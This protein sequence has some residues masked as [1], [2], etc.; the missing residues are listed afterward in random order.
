MSEKSTQKI[1]RIDLGINNRKTGML[2]RIDP[3]ATADQTPRVSSERISSDKRQTLEMPAVEAPSTWS[4]WYTSRKQ[5]LKDGWKSLFG[6]KEGPKQLEQKAAQEIGMINNLA[7]QTT[8]DEQA[9]SNAAI[10]KIEHIAAAEK[11]P[12]NT[13]KVEQ[14]GQR[15]IDRVTTLKTNLFGKERQ[16]AS[17][18]RQVVIEE[19]KSDEESVEELKAFIPQIENFITMQ[20]TVIDR[21]QQIMRAQAEN[22]ERQ[23]GQKAIDESVKN[24]RDKLNQ[25]EEDTTL[26]REEKLDKKADLSSQLS[27]VL[28]QAHNFRTTENE[29]IV[30]AILLTEVKDALEKLKSGDPNPLRKIR[31]DRNKEFK[32][33]APK[34]SQEATQPANQQITQPGNIDPAVGIPKD[35][36][37]QTTGEAFPQV[38]DTDVHST[39]IPD[40]VTDAQID[41]FLS[42]EPLVASDYTT[43]TPAQIAA[44][45]P[46]KRREIAQTIEQRITDQV[47]DPGANADRAKLQALARTLEQIRTADMPKNDSGDRTDTQQAT[48]FQELYNASEAAPAADLSEAVQAYNQREDA[49]QIST[50][51]LLM[52]AGTIEQIARKLLGAKLTTSTHQIG[53]RIY[54]TLNITPAEKDQTVLR[55]QGLLTTL[56]GKNKELVINFITALDQNQAYAQQVTELEHAFDAAYPASTTPDDLSAFEDLDVTASAQAQAVK[57]R[58]VRSGKPD[59]I[60]GPNASIEYTSPKTSAIDNLPSLKDEEPEEK[61]ARALTPEE[62]GRLHNPTNTHMDDIDSIE[63]DG[64]TMIGFTEDD[65][66]APRDQSFAT[67]LEEVMGNSEDLVEEKPTTTSSKREFPTYSFD[68]TDEDADAQGAPTMPAKGK[69]TSVRSSQPATGVT[70]GQWRSAL[71][72]KRTKGTLSPETAA[73]LIATSPT[74]DTLSAAKLLAGKDEL[75][76]RNM[77]AELLAE[78]SIPQ[79]Q[80]DR[81]SGQIRIALQNERTRKST[82]P[83][84]TAV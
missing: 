20:Q 18:I 39:V 51:G 37:L 1:P 76:L 10:Q 47:N 6:K 78:P 23:M 42:S 59:R 21:K 70:S 74:G 49:A 73:L 83:R 2:E 64:D 22:S 29:I 58:R 3:D 25:I 14:Q 19:K 61:M 34:A 28:T 13:Q 12:L 72:E 38:K 27:G 79:L 41:A 56:S 15:F 33:F 77:E 62:K 50:R 7:D 32:I 84:R 66:Q 9:A 8:R 54:E 11:L 65:I 82:P 40:T 71:A 45:T 63:E 52:D 36:K 55:A 35:F 30:E 75:T 67:T 5:L 48:R 60:K 43:L 81:A 68:T 26:T 57:P 69:M 46:E 24:L 4:D 16:I 31:K 44:Y 80:K 53:S 17:E